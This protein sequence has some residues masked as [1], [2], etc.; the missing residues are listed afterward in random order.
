MAKTSF[1]RLVRQKA[2]EIIIQ[3]G[4]ERLR[5]EEED[6]DKF[7]MTTE[8]DVELSKDSL[9]STSLIMRPPPLNITSLKR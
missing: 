8:E 7:M 4:G 2:K 5:E 3:K 1:G 9:I 6:E